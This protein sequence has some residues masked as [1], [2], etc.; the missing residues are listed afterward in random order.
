MPA[1]TTQA[2]RDANS[3]ETKHVIFGNYIPLG[4]KNLLKLTQSKF[5]K[6]DIVQ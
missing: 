3:K 1:H 5:L 4:I 2:E 6:V